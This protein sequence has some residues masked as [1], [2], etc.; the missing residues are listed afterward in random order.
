MSD[1]PKMELQRLERIADM[2]LSA[3]SILRDRFARRA[4]AFDIIL[5][6]VSGILCGT[7]FL[8][9]ALIRYFHL[10]TEKIR[11]LLGICAILVFILSIVGLRVDWKEKTSRYQH[12]CRTLANIKA[13][14]RELL[15]TEEDHQVAEGPEFLR[16]SS[17][18]MSDLIPIPDAEFVKLKAKHKQKVEISRLLDNYPS[19]PIWLLR[20]KLRLRDLHAMVKENAKKGDDGSSE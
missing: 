3:H 14:S 7:T 15:G 4:T 1:K 19:I 20:W 17:F 8:D 10:D 2:M 6:V 9:P 18:A 16:T 13:K 11:A 12:A 5:L